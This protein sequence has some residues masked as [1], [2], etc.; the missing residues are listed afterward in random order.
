MNDYQQREHDKAV[1]TRQQL[2]PIAAALGWTLLP[3]DLDLDYP[4]RAFYISNGAGLHVRCTVMWNKTD[5]FEFAASRWPTYTDKDGAVQR[6]TPHDM[7]NE[8]VGNKFLPRET[9]PTVIAA[10]SRDPVAVAKQIRARL[11]PEYRRIYAAL[12]EMADSRQEYADS[13]A[14]VIARL[15]EATQEDREEREKPY[16]I[17][18]MPGDLVTM[19]YRSPGSIRIDLSCSDMCAVIGF[20]RERRQ[21]VRS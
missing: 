16:F 3:D 19:D 14:S 11:L 9:T 12:Q 6:V 21:G 2:E 4:P 5:R 1:Q 10:R 7:S 15:F 13:E 17:R 18:N 8:Y 20:L